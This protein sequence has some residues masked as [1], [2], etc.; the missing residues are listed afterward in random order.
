MIEDDW[1]ISV[2]Y[3]LY[4]LRYTVLTDFHIRSKAGQRSPLRSPAG[5]SPG[6]GVSLVGAVM[7]CYELMTTP[8]DSRI[9][10]M[11]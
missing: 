2:I 11:L 10:K 6:V 8:R 5:A 3:R 9:L 4:H 7:A 1:S